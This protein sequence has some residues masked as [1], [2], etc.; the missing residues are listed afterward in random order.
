MPD[1]EWK[2]NQYVTVVRQINEFLRLLFKAS[3]PDPISTSLLDGAAPPQPSGTNTD[4]P[5]GAVSQPPTGTTSMDELPLPV[6]SS[7]PRSAEKRARGKRAGARQGAA[8]SSGTTTADTAQA[9]NTSTTQ[10]SPILGGPGDDEVAG[11][12]N[13]ASAQGSP[14][15]VGDRHPS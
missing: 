9:T 7:A 12:S 15:K 11:E 14:C 5:T 8:S 10:H 1:D 4:Q 6:F 13:G 3:S 2:K